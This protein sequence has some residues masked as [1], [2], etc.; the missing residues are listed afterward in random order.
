MSLSVSTTRR[1]DRQREHRLGQGARPLVRHREDDAGHPGRG[2]SL[3]DAAAAHTWV[4]WA[5]D[6]L[7]AWHVP[8]FVI[9]T[10]YLSGRFTWTAR[11]SAPLVRTVAVPYVIFEA[12]W[13]GSATGSAAW[14]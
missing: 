11:G 2:R 8:A 3:L 12:P 5:Y 14:S 9:V 1:C 7:Y 4:S 13:P 6:F 10:G